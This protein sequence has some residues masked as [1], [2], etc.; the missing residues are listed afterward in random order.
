[1][2]HSDDNVANVCVY[3]IAVAADISANYWM[4]LRNIF[5]LQVSQFYAN[6]VICDMDTHS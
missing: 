6:G 3:G 1:M 4:C 2:F 5:Q